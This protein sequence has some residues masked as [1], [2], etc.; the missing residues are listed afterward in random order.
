[1]RRVPGGTVLEIT[2]REGRKRQVKRMCA[3]VG[4][5]VLRLERTAFGPLT[6]GALAPGRWRRLN[7][8]ELAA[9]RRAAAGL[10]G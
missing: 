7:E 1:M 9:L 10:P 5:R 2:I 8:R 4:H 3:A 6:L